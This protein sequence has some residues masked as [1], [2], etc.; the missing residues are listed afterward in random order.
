MQDAPADAALARDAVMTAGTLSTT[1]TG[2]SPWRRALLLLAQLCLV[3]AFLVFWQLAVSERNVAFFS[4]PLIIGAKLAELVLDP[5]FH[6][7]IAVTLAEIAVGYGIG[8]AVGLALGFLLGRSRFLSNLL[9]PF[10]IGLYSIPKIALA[11]LFIVWLGLGMASKVAVVVLATFFLVFFNTYSGLLNVNEELLRLA[12]LMG[13][14][15]HHCI[16]RVVL[17]SAGDQIFIGLKTA[18]PYAVIGAVIGE[19]IGS[20]AGLGHFILYASQTYD[21]PALFSGIAA[22]IV[23]V[24]VCNFTLNALERRLIR[25]RHIEGAA[26][27]L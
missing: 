12:R 27:Q 20:N 15:W 16:F 8:A 23:I 25:W 21:A 2:K 26:V 24:F 22:L 6:H 4:R 17:P 7:D 13:A 14:S 10:I 3:A 1:R 11:P 19:Y 18:V 9:E 5:D